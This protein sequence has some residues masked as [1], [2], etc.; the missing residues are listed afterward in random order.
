MR[1]PLSNAY[2]AS[3]QV[4]ALAPIS[5]LLCSMAAAHGRPPEL[6]NIERIL[7]EVICPLAQCIGNIVTLLGGVERV[8]AGGCQHQ[9]ASRLLL[10]EALWPTPAQLSEQPPQKEMPVTIS[11]FDAIF[12]TVGSDFILEGFCEPAILLTDTLREDANA[13]EWAPLKKIVVDFQEKPTARMQRPRRRSSPLATK[14]KFES[15]EENECRGNGAPTEGPA[16]TPPVVIDCSSSS[17][18]SRGAIGSDEPLN[19]MRPSEAAADLIESSLWEDLFSDAS[20]EEVTDASRQPHGELEDEHVVSFISVP[21]SVSEAQ[22]HCST[23]RLGTSENSQINGRLL[24]GEALPEGGFSA[25]KSE[26]SPCTQVHFDAVSV[27]PSAY[28]PIRAPQT[29]EASEDDS[30]DTTSS[31]FSLIGGG[32]NLGVNDAPACASRTSAA[33]RVGASTLHE[34]QSRDEFLDQVLPSGIGHGHDDILGDDLFSD[35]VP[36][37]CTEAAVFAGVTSVLTFSSPGDCRALIGASIAHL[38]CFSGMLY[39]V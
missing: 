2:A 7:R 17:T 16:E 28:P 14:I 9:G 18:A 24:F 12:P 4:K 11:I 22:I 10:Y 33:Q 21:N 3:A 39:T 6:V 1:P 32:F 13:G 26:R 35:V 27:L 15:D 36:F 29:V 31:S 19:S 25:R 30:L 23:P 20:G 38:S 37:N 34:N 5:P 8:F